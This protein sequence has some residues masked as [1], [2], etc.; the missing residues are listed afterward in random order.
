MNNYTVLNFEGETHILA[1]ESKEEGFIFTPENLI[2]NIDMLGP[3]SCYG[4]ASDALRHYFP[5]EYEDKNISTAREAELLQ[6]IN[7]VSWHDAII[8]YHNEVGFT[9]EELGPVLVNEN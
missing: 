8:K 5:E 6:K 9:L 2:E 1:T 4:L 3:W 7:G